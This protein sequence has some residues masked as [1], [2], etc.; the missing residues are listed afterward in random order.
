MRKNRFKPLFLICMM[1]FVLLTGV[2]A[3]YYQLE[4][5]EQN[6]LIYL[7]D[8]WKVTTKDGEFDN[9][10]LKDIPYIVGITQ[11]KVTEISIEKTIPESLKGE[12]TSLALKLDF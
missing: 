4:P 3:V 11:S 5:Y 8:G 10:S 1:M 2:I 12:V 6:D 9:K 7:E